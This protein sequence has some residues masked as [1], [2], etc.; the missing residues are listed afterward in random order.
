MKQRGLGKGLSALIPER[1]L[2]DLSDEEQVRPTF[3]VET[4][5]IARNK[6]QPREDFNSAKMDGLISSVKKNGLIQPILV[7]RTDQGYE[8]ICGER[9]LRAAKTIGLEKVPVIIKDASD[10]ESLGLAVIENVQREDLNPVERARAYKK[11]IDEFDLSQEDL[12]ETLAKDRSSVANTLRLLKLP[13]S[14]QGYILEN[15]ITM[16]HAMAL[17]SLATPA[18]QIDACKKIINQHLS[19][20]EIEISVREQSPAKTKKKIIRRPPEIVGMEEDLQRVLA[21]Q[22]KIKAG[23][24]KGKIEIEYYSAEDLNRIVGIL[25]L[26]EPK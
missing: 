11:L 7:R 21:T 4:S 20:R 6:N 3:W 2:S 19:V 18:L 17:L 26:R 8:L 13:L 15:K 16:G 22:V 25:A 12:A 24:K 10:A 9:R 14:I 1:K 5:L 23:R